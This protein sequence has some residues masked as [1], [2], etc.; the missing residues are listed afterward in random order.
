MKTWKK[1]NLLSYETKD[2]LCKVKARANSMNPD[3]SLSYVEEGA[4]Q[5]VGVG[6]FGGGD[7]DAPCGVISQCVEVG[8]LFG[9]DVDLYCSTMVYV[10]R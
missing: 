7:I 9:C 5:E 6:D 3:C 8:P 4:C 10:L 1:P 2:L